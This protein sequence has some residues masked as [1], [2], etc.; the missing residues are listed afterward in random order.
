MSIY[1]AGAVIGLGSLPLTCGLFGCMSEC[2]K[3]IKL[4][5]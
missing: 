4:T 2:I 1:R 5:I 3:S